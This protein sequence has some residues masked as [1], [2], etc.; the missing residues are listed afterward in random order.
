MLSSNGS[1]HWLFP[2]VTVFTSHPRALHA[3]SFEIGVSTRA[4]PISTYALSHVSPP[5]STPLPHTF[6]DHPPPGVVVHGCC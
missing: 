4:F 1:K 6:D 5:S 3:E 2:L